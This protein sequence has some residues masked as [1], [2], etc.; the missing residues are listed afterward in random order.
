[1]RRARGGEW[2]LEKVMFLGMALVTACG[3]RVASWTCRGAR[4][5]GLC[6][7]LC[8]LTS[9]GVLKQESKRMR[10]VFGSL[11]HFV[12]GMPHSKRLP[13]VVHVLHGKK[14]FDKLRHTI[15]HIDFSDT[16]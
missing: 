16:K 9:V 4:S 3:E 14:Y 2:S 15:D 12:G 13:S 5:Q 8:T 6:A 11:Q 10:R 7:L 1:M